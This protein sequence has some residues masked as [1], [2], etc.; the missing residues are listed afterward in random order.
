MHQVNSSR[1]I[2]GERREREREREK[3]K[4]NWCLQLFYESNYF[5]L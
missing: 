4:L 1:D 5:N 3:E 2:E